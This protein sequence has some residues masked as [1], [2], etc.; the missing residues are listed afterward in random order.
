MIF[1]FDSQRVPTDAGRRI[2]HELTGV[3]QLEKGVV[4]LERVTEQTVAV[5]FLVRIGRFELEQHRAGRHLILVDDQKRVI[6]R[7]SLPLRLTV[8]DVENVNGHGDRALEV[9]VGDDGEQ[10][11]HVLL[12]AIDRR[13]QVDFAALIDGELL[14]LVV[15]AVDQ[16][17]VEIRIERPDRADRLPSREILVDEEFVLL[18]FER[19]WVVVE[20]VDVDANGC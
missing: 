5:G 1:G 3:E 9:P 18:A 2:E 20:I 6:L 17:R 12:F 4:V 19:R 13:S 11:V 16:T 10:L 8:V 14:L 15:N 7:R